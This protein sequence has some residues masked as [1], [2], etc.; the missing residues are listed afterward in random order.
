MQKLAKPLFLLNLYI[1]ATTR[2]GR[3]EKMG[4]EESGPAATRFGGAL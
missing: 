2:N 4:I 3:S 1:S